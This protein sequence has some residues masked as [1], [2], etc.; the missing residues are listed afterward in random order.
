MKT[1]KE[2]LNEKKVRIRLSGKGSDATFSVIDRKTDKELLINIKSESEAREL[3]KKKG[4]SVGA[5]TERV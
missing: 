5:G 1:F 2:I 4:W 3:I